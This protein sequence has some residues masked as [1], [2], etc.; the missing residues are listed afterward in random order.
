MADEV[1]GGSVGLGVS[2]KQ[3]AAGLVNGLSGE[4]FERL[5]WAVQARGHREYEQEAAVIAER[6]N[7][8][9]RA[10]AAYIRR[11][12]PEAIDGIPIKVVDGRQWEFS[13]N[14][15]TVVLMA[16]PDDFTLAVRVIN[17]SA[18]EDAE[19]TSAGYWYARAESAWMAWSGLVTAVQAAA[20]LEL[21]DEE[22]I[23]SPAP[24]GPAGTDSPI[25][26]GGGDL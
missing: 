2:S 7:E 14:G 22:Y 23:D 9:C 16:F 5:G 26:D 8:R 24:T 11:W 15:A 17:I 20:R 19:R 6:W 3:V 21:E 1:G 25:A 12:M 13:V 10:N 4:E 18:G